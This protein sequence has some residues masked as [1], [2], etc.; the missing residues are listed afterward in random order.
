M[1]KK[2]KV[3]AIVESFLEKRREMKEV[4]VLRDCGC[5]STIDTIKQTASIVYCQMHEQAE[6]MLTSLQDIRKL[7]LSTSKRLVLEL[8]EEQYALNH[9]ADVVGI[10]VHK[11]TKE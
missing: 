2:S 1:N 11:A 3:D 7:A 4:F 5:L 10:I 6:T 9:I 8:T